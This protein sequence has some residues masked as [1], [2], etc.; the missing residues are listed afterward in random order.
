MDDLWIAAETEQIQSVDTFLNVS[1]LRLCHA[2]SSGRRRGQSYDQQLIIKTQPVLWESTSCLKHTF[3][4]TADG[5]RGRRPS[6][7]CVRCVHAPAGR[8]RTQLSITALS[9]VLPSMPCSLCVAFTGNMK[10]FT[11]QQQSR[12]EPTRSACLSETF[13]L[14]D[15]HIQS[16]QSSASDWSLHDPQRLSGLCDFRDIIIYRCFGFF[17]SAL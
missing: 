14:S 9:S 1:L 11:H 16:A 15:P 2:L 10:R 4:V 13:T 7:E 6:A 12:D 8:S 5:L 17:C 3:L